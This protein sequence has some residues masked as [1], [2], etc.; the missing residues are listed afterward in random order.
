MIV[1][2]EIKIDKDDELDA[3]YINF[4]NTCIGPQDDVETEEIE[5]GVFRTFNENKTNITYRY[6]ILDFS[7]IDKN[8]LSE[9][10]GINL[11]DY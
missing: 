2:S 10:T 6:V 9:I 3:V 5:N 4:I 7:Y 11:K 1:N 8:H